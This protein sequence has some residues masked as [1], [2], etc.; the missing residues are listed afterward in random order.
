M[1][2]NLIRQALDQEAPAKRAA[3]WQETIQHDPALNGI[4]R[5]LS[6]DALIAPNK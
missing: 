2:V 4:R 6:Y 5:R 1:A 3:F